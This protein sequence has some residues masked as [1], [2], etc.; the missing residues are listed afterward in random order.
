MRIW[1]ANY[2]G[3]SLMK[4]KRLLASSMV[5]MILIS[6]SLPALAAYYVSCDFCGYQTATARNI[7]T[8]TKSSRPCD[9]GHINC[10]ISSV[11]RVYDLYCN[12]CGYGGGAYGGEEFLYYVHTSTH[13]LLIESIL[14]Y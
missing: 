3:G 11:Y 8:I 2:E 1:L 13:R 4:R 12:K 10:M 14:N 7:R 9:Q 5:L 6:L